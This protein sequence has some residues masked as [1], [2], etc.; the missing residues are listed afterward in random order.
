MSTIP[1]WTPLSPNLYPS[2][3]PPQKKPKKKK[4]KKKNARKLKRKLFQRTEKIENCREMFPK[5]K[6]LKTVQRNVDKNAKLW[7]MYKQMFTEDAI[8]W[9]IYD[10]IKK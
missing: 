9:K 3:H 8:F 4:K 7:N 10:H 2:P 1:S 5:L 6:I